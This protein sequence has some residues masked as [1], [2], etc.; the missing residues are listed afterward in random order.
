MDILE[1]DKILKAIE[2]L[3]ITDETKKLV[4]AMMLLLDF[5]EKRTI[6]MLINATGKSLAMDELDKELDKPE[7][8]MSLEY[9]DFLLDELDYSNRVEAELKKLGIEHNGELEDRQAVELLYK[10]T[11]SK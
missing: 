1:K 10:M 8:K 5:D 4:I 11:K 2:C 9:I 6:S 3:D 7:K